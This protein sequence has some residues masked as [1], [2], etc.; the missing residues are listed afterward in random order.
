M[1]GRKEAEKIGRKRLTLEER[2]EEEAATLAATLEELRSLDVEHRRA[3]AA[4]EHGARPEKVFSDFPRE[5][6]A[7]FKGRFNGAVPGVGTDYRAGF[8]GV[9]PS[10]PERDPLTP[11]A[12]ER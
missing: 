10:L 6:L 3:L 2:A 8:R 4:V 9:G 11:K 5:L 7:W 12:R 1:K